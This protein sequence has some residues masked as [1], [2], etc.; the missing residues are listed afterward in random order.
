MLL[1]LLIFGLVAVIA[2]LIPVAASIADARTQQLVVQRTAALSEVVQRAHTALVRGDAEG[3]QLYLDRFHEVYGEPVLVIDERGDSFASAGELKR[4]AQVDALAAAAARTLPQWSLST[5][6]PVG[7]PRAVVAMPVIAAGGLPAGVVVVLVDVRP[8]QA[9]VARGWVLV[10]L[11]GLL[12]LGALIAAVLFLTRWVLRPVRALELAVDAVAE[13]RD[14]SLARPSGPPELR[15]LTRAFAAMADGVENS[16]EQQRGFVADASHQLRTPL[17]AIRLRIDGLPRPDDDVDTLRAV[18]DDLDRL[19]HTV[20]RMLTLAEAEHRASARTYGQDAADDPTPRSC[21]TSARELGERHR[22]PLRSAG[23]RL[24][25]DDDQEVVVPCGMRDLEEMVDSL[26]GNAAKYAGDG[27][28]VWL[29]LRQSAD[30]VELTVEDSGALL[31][32]DDLERMG[33]RF[34]RAAA[35]RARPGTGLGLAI[36]VQLMKAS[37]GRAEFTR[38][39]AGG[40]CARLIWEAA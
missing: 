17:A 29:R 36:V 23:L 20:E 9:D 12:L 6:T 28:T 4:D 19:E 32:D 35:H 10:A 34:W 38:S 14:P 16:L 8:A 13:H 39:A 24:V 18:D 27:S 15:S 2:V 11:A 21:V 37:G 3:L 30:G 5:V 40:L 31:G 1:P 7:P 25:I 26:I 22:A 33:S